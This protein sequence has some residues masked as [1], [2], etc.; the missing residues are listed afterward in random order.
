MVICLVEIRAYSDRVLHFYSIFAKVWEWAAIAANGQS[1]GIIILQKKN[2]GSVTPIVKSKQV[3]DLVFSTPSLNTLIRLIF[4]KGLERVVQLGWRLLALLGSF[5]EISTLLFPLQS[6][7]RVFQ[8]LQ[9]QAHAFSNFISSNALLDI[10]FIS[11][12]FSQCNGQSGHARRQAR[13]DQCLVNTCQASLFNSNNPLRLGRT[14]SNHS[15]LLLT[16]SRNVISHRNVFLFENLWL[17]YVDFHVVVRKALCFQ[18]HS[19]PMHAFIHILSR[20]WKNLID[21]K[22]KGNCNLDRDLK[23]TEVCIQALEVEESENSL[24]SPNIIRLNILYNKHKAFLR[25]NST[26]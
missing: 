17:D 26:K 3:L 18:A 11:S 19:T 4:K 2:L 9:P 6:I 25:Q 12:A 23:A 14:F 1:G 5:W 20:V 8:L 22:S 10:G 21:W 15:P 24:D 7:K 16:A 13:L